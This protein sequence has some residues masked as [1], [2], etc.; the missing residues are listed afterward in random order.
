MGASLYIHQ[1]PQSNSS[2]LSALNQDLKDKALIEAQRTIIAN[3]RV[4]LDE[5][6]RNSEMTLEE[7]WSTMQEISES[8]TQQLQ[9]IDFRGVTKRGTKDTPGTLAVSEKEIKQKLRETSKILKSY[10]SA[11]ND[12]SK[13]KIGE[14]KLFSKKEIDDLKKE[15]KTAQEAIK[16][17]QSGE[18][19]E[20]WHKAIGSIVGHASNIIGVLVEYYTAALLQDLYRI[21]G[22]NV[23]VK[24]T[25]AQAGEI[26]EKITSDLK[27]T[28]DTGIEEKDIGISVKR[29][30]AISKDFMLVKTKTAKLESLLTASRTEIDRNGLYNVI[31]N[32]GRV[33]YK[34]SESAGRGASIP[35]DTW[36][37][38][39]FKGLVQ[40][41]HKIFALTALSGELAD[42]DFASYLIVNDKIYNILELVEDYLS[43]KGGGNL[44]KSISSDF[45]PKQKEIQKRHF[46]LVTK[47]LEAE[48]YRA[49]GE[50]RSNEMIRQINSMSIIIKARIR[51][52]AALLSK[53]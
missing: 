29:T 26:Y 5:T 39:N 41:L 2:Y 8:V 34:F 3:R 15:I 11:I 30:S 42:N 16:K 17:L 32:H 23:K 20:D 28:F 10:T 21:D 22:K 53:T 50:A 12:F 1:N 27:I 47:S 43:G 14:N 33:Y 48:D 19:V 25:G 18:P 45:I 13:D 9:S 37:Y 4:A 46:A 24:L 52:S 6:F 7:I 49:A 51:F 44:L 40:M 38:E 36:S 35:T 31:A